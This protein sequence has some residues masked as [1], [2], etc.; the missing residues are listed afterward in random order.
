MKKQLI[1]ISD[2]EGAFGIFDSDK[3]LLFNGEEEWRI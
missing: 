1:V 2:M 3:K